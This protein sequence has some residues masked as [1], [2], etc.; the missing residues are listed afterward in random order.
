MLMKLHVC[1][2]VGLLVGPSVGSLK[3]TLYFTFVCVYVC[4][5]IQEFLIEQY[6]QNEVWQRKIWGMVNYRAASLHSPSPLIPS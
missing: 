5:F 6:T 3:V 2:L 1:L 4:T